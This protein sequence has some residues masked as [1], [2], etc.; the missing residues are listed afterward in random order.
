[1][2]HRNRGMLRQDKYMAKIEKFA[3]SRVKH[4]T[5]EV[6]I[7]FYLLQGRYIN[8]VTVIQKTHA[9]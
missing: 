5:S 8:R 9:A 1:M 7:F 3:R 4:R 2:H 6:T